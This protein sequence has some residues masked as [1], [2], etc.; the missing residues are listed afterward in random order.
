MHNTKAKTQKK[1]TPLIN[2]HW[3]FKSSLNVNDNKWNIIIGQSLR[4]KTFILGQTGGN[5]KPNP[6]WSKI[7]FMTQGEIA[8]ISAEYFSP[9]GVLCLT[10][11]PQETTTTATKQHTTTHG[12]LHFSE[13]RLWFFSE[14][15][16]RKKINFMMNKEVLYEPIQTVSAFPVFRANPVLSG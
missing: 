16:S 9:S 4:D 15:R 10:N 13:I 12:V 14:T 7:D 11:F 5:Y 3:A 1:L 2:L 8:G 6:H